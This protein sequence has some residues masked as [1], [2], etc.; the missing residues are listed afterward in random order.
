MSKF[1]LSMVFSAVSFPTN[2]SA[3]LVKM[4]TINFYLFACFFLEMC[5]FIINLG[6]D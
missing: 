5:Y 4:S 1:L 2:P 3:V 6:S